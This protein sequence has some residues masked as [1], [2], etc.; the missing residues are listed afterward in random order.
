M[1][2]LISVVSEELG[3]TIVGFTACLFL[4]ACCFLGYTL[5]DM[6]RNRPRKK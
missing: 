6:W 4:G 3:W 5:F 2:E 1:L